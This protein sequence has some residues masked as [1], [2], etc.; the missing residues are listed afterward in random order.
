MKKVVAMSR[1][2][3][4]RLGAGSVAAGITGR[5]VELLEPKILWPS[6][7]LAPSDTVRFG[8]I[9]TGTQGCDLLRAS[10][11]MPGIECVAAADLFDARHDSVKK[12]L[13][14]NLDTT[15][16]YRRV[17]DRKDIDALIVATPDHWHGRLVIEAARAGKDVYCEKP[18]SHTLEDGFAMMDAVRKNKRICQIGSQRVSSILYAKAKEIWDSGRLGEVDTIEA[19]WDRNTDSGAWVFPIPPDANFA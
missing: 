10:R 9:G 19:V 12:I 7:T 17:L 1:R 2:D 8:I 4:V 6:S 15:R 3:F 11:A 16:D 18:M 13:K 5:K 14:K